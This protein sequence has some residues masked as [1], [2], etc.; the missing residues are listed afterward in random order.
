MLQVDEAVNMPAGGG[1][2]RAEAMGVLAALAHDLAT[3]P[4]VDDWIAAARSEDLAP[5]QQAALRE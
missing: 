3:A 2:K 1:E 4:A 5:S